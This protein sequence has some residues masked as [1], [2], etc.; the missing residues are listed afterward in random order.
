[1]R[2]YRPK[3]QADLESALDTGIV[4]ISAVS[5]ADSEGQF[6][7]T[8]SHPLLAPLDHVEVQVVPNEWSSYPAEHSFLAWAITEIPAAFAEP[9]DNFV[10]QSSGLRVQEAL[11]ALS[12]SFTS[13]L[14]GGTSVAGTQSD[15]DDELMTDVEGDDFGGETAS[16]EEDEEEEGFDYFGYGSEEDDVFGLGGNGGSQTPTHVTAKVD[17]KTADRIRRDFRT[18]RASGFKVGVICGFENTVENNIVSLSVRVDKLCLSSETLE[19]WN[20]TL[21]DYIILLIRYDRHYTALEDAYE[22]ASGLSNMQF[23]LRKCRRYKPSLHHALKAFHSDNATRGKGTD[24]TDEAE[25][26]RS[27]LNLLGIGQSIDTFM[28]ADFVSLLKLRNGSGLNWD[29]ANKQLA[30]MSRNGESDD[31]DQTKLPAFIAK[32]HFK[33]EQELSLPLIAAQFAMRYFVR[34]TDYCMVCHQQV[35]GNF[36]TLKPYVCGNSLCLFQYMSM[37][38]GPSVNQE[39]R[40]QPNVV[41]LLIS[42]CYAGLQ[43]NMS[44]NFA[45]G[46]G[47][48]DFPTGLSLQVPKIFKGSSISAYNTQIP[49][50][51]SRM[52]VPGALSAY[53]PPPVNTGWQDP[54]EEF[55]GSV[56]INGVVLVD[57]IKGRFSKNA[58]TFELQESKDA[59]RF[60]EGSWVAIVATVQTSP[61]ENAILHGRVTSIIGSMVTLAIVSVLPHLDAQIGEN[62]DAYMVLYNQNLDDLEGNRKAAAILMQLETIPSVATL[63]SYLTANPTQQIEKWDRLTPAAS[64]LLRWI[65]ASNRSYIVQVDECPTENGNPE[66]GLA[67]Q[68]EHISGV[69]GWLQFRFAQ[70]SPEKEVQFQEALRQVNKPHK[71]IL[72]WHGSSLSNWHSIIRQ[73]LNFEHVHNGRAYGNGVYFGHD[74]NTSLGYSG[75]LHGWGLADSSASGGKPYWP[76]SVLKIGSA[77]SLNELVN[78][79][80]KFASNNHFCMVVQHVHWIQCRCLFI[81]P[82]QLPQ[83]QAAQTAAIKPKRSDTS[84]VRPSD[85]PEFI[86][87]PANEAKGTSGKLFVPQGAIPT[88]EDKGVQ[89]ASMSLKQDAFG[90]EG[91]SEDEDEEDCTFLTMSGGSQGDTASSTPLSSEAPAIILDTTKTD[92]RPFTLDLDTLPKLSPPSYATGQAQKT[93]AK[94]IQKLQATQSSVPIHELGWFIDF[95]KITNMFHWIVELHSFDKSMPLAKDM[96]K[97]KVTS[98]VLELRFGREFPFSPPFVRVIRP[99]FLPFAM[100]GGGHVTAGGAMCMELLTTDGWLPINSLEGVLVQVRMAMTNTEPRPARLENTTPIDMHK[101]SG[102]SKVQHRSMDYGVSEAF[103]AYKRA[104]MAHGWKVPADLLEATTDMKE[105]EGDK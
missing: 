13:A 54:A 95:D 92:F 51:A 59:D 15:N 4:G 25:S 46:R 86:Q 64:K 73:G 89:Q 33:S 28:D 22:R 94:E 10:M 98:V 34:C 56:S 85:I 97:A 11:A 50:P 41:D 61:T 7:F 29:Q 31:V 32:D 66:E 24:E 48:R 35:E 67:R 105:E 78:L 76:N 1:M 2:D 27:E 30:S 91:D 45:P 96:E 74:F 52:P 39:I 102:K 79:P 103:E 20:L 69:E 55:A 49:V 77:V 93:L 23:R 58:S 36:E 104:A 75:R 82:L 101:N 43:A 53:A 26:T 87:D 12:Q 81:Q 21:E 18:A 19:A 63:R 70:G 88:I 40:N 5:K 83:A 8:F 38:L 37:G 47:V 17:Q 14:G 90:H 72:A 84:T 68:Q 62:S 16:E 57:P 44:A 100:G 71:T 60:K 80:E 42:F 3:Y 9:L 65:V 6:V 99:R